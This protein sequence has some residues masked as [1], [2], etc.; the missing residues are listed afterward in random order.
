MLNY[1]FKELVIFL[2]NCA[3]RNVYT[4]SLRSLIS[5]NVLTVL[6]KNWVAFRTEIKNGF[7]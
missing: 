6:E 5:I 7:L 1:Y 4:I 2:G 3:I